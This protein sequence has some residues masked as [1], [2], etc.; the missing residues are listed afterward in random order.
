MP[1]MDFSEEVQAGPEP[2]ILPHRTRSR[3]T[4]WPTLT[5]GSRTGDEP[6][7]GAVY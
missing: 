6:F 7:P 3:L 4:G 5:Q 1:A 2:R